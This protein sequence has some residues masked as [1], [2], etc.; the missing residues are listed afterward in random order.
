MSPRSSEER[1][2]EDRRLGIAGPTLIPCPR[3]KE[4]ASALAIAT[5]VDSPLFRRSSVESHSERL[6]PGDPWIARDATRILGLWL[7]STDVGLEWG[8]GRST[9]WFARR[10][11]SI[12]SVEGNPKWFE[13]VGRSLEREGLGNARLVLCD[14]KRG[15]AGYVGVV[16]QFPDGSLDFALVD[17]SFRSTCANRVLAKIR[18]GGLLVIANANRFLPSASRSPKS[19]KTSEGPRE[20]T[21]A[22]ASPEIGW[23]RF[24]EKVSRWR[25]LWTSDGVADTVLWVKP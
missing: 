10:V 5:M 18:Q 15:P 8:T 23:R 14:D 12:T 7:R 21:E 6:N 2:D 19:R 17:G 3:R 13:I 4:R 1:E 16:D 20:S 22:E 24:L 11:K 9:V 25:C